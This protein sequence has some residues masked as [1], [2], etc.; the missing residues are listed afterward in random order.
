MPA[1]VLDKSGGRLEKEN[2]GGRSHPRSCIA[3]DQYQPCDSAV[4]Y[5]A[6]GVP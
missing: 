3:S 2:G 6:H 5:A 4:S 1:L